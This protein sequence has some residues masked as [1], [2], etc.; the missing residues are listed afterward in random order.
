MNMTPPKDDFA[1]LTQLRAELQ[2]CPPDEFE[3]RREHMLMLVDSIMDGRKQ[4]SSDYDE[5]VQILSDAFLGGVTWDRISSEGEISAEAFGPYSEL[6][7][8][9]TG[10]DSTRLFALFCILECRAL[11]WINSLSALAQTTKPSKVKDKFRWLPHELIH[12]TGKALKAEKIKAGRTRT[13]KGK[14]AVRE[15]WINAGLHQRRAE[16][17][18]LVAFCKAMAEL[19]K[20]GADTIQKNWI[21]KWRKELPLS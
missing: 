16:R 4:Q 19:H 7:L 9:V 11:E 5:T 12:N 8:N 3:Q 15:A 20:C 6:L 10:L 21:P 18:E 2:E 14:G 1:C 17:G 13:P